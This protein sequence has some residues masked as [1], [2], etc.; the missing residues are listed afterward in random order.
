M[1]GMHVVAGLSNCRKSGS[2]PCTSLYLI[3]L[4]S[5]STYLYLILSTQQHTIMLV[6]RY[7]AALIARRDIGA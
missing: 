2:R 7:Y 6:S 1:S 5:I 3:K 4:Q